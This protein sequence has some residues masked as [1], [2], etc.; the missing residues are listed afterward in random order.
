[1]SWCNCLSSSTRAII[2][3]NVSHCV[4]AGDHIEIHDIE[5]LE[6]WCMPSFL[7]PCDECDDGCWKCDRGRIILTREQAEA[8]DVAIVI[9]HN[10]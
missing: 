6:C 3:A 4:V 10:G 5:S 7:L 1:M 2:M 8:C 9:I